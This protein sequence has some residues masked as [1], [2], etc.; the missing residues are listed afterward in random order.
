MT[1]LFPD[2]PTDTGFE[3]SV[4]TTQFSNGIHSLVVKATNVS[5]A[6]TI[7]PTVQVTIS[8]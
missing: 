3:A 2:A 8:N 1:S 7:F 5:G 4:D 6:V